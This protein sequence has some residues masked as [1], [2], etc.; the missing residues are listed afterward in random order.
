MSAFRALGALLA[1]LVVCS[2]PARAE[3]RTAM[4]YRSYPVE[5]ESLA[6]VRQDI[7][8]KAPQALR[9]GA[10]QAETRIRYRWR[11]RYVAAGP[12]CVA[13]R[14]T[15]DLIV[16]IILPEWARAH[17]APPSVQAAWRRY[18][19]ELRRHEHHH[20]DIAVATAHELDS[21]L[22]N[23]PRDRS[24]NALAKWIDGHAERILAEERRRQ[25]DLDRISAPVRL[26]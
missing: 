10:W 19:D 18:R 12:G 14:P 17:F 1:L 26:Y 20:R 6:A 11:V 3:V 2:V 7:S 4:G 5:G 16:T 22:R 13:K 24:C 15:V 8:Y 21:L 23:A 9:D 25:T